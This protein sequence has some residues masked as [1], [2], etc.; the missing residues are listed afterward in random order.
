MRCTAAK[1]LPTLTPDIRNMAAARRF[2]VT[3][4]VQGVFFR[5][6][7]REVAQSLQLG[8]HAINL[9]D[10]SVEVLACG[11]TQALDQLAEWLHE[12]PRLANVTD[13]VAEEVE[14]QELAG[15]RVG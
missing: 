8:G 1:T 9:P 2:I 14:W 7:T 11:S 4:R 6:S 5:D 13:V 12:G 10:G 3:G 15:F